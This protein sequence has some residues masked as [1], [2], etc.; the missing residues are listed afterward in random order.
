MHKQNRSAGKEHSR[1]G[2]FLVCS[3]MVIAVF[4]PRAFR[5]EASEPD[6]TTV[7]EES[8]SEAGVEET[9]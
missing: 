9:K 4:L 5:K 6:D 8:D 3:L 7:W 1:L 2:V